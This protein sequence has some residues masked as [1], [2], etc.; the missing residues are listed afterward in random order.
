MILYEKRKLQ[1]LAR[2]RF[3]YCQ[4]LSLKLL[5]F[6]FSLPIVLVPSSSALNHYSLRC[7][8]AHVLS[9]FSH[10]YLFATPWIVALQASLSIGFSKQEYWSGLSCPPLGDLADPGIEPVSLKSPALAGRLFTTST[11]QEVPLSVYVPVCVCVC[12]SYVLN[13]LICCRTFGLFLYL[14]YCK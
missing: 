13:P 8:C 11:T 9:G 14:G 12:I 7:V 3:N 1:L 6:L 4:L 5:T 10:V 2:H